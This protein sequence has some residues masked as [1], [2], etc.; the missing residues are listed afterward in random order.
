MGAQVD[1]ENLNDA[2]IR[3]RAAAIIN[4]GK[5]GDRTAIKPITEILAN[6]S[7]IDWLRACAAVALGRLRCEETVMPLVNALRDDSVTVSKA[8]ILALGDV[9]SRQAVL[10]LG[11]VLADHDKED[12]HALAVT[13][14]GAIGGPE[15]DIT[16]LRALE[17]PHSGVR[18][19]A[20]LALGERRTAAAV[21]PLTELLK[22]SDECLRAVAASSLGLI[23]DIRA[24]AG[25]I[26]ALDDP[27]ATVR[28]V[29][30]SSLGCLGDCR[31]VR[32]LERALGDESRAV[33]QQ[34]AAAL[35]KIGRNKESLKVESEAEHD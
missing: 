20:A 34:A 9:G 4:A 25:L 6:K 14:L 31:A 29:A 28:S 18:S 5:T 26:E 19:R 27:A 10:P 30:A 8:A 24:A 22:D 7:E 13:V 3:V 2:N 32:P 1:L 12:L 33:R 23:G 11:A 21:V 16:L 15:V 17:G 35:S